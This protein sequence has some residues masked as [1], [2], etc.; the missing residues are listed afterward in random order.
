M[1]PDQEARL[2]ELSERIIE[3]ALLDADPQNWT[4]CEKTP[5]EM[6]E[7]ERGDAQWC[8][9][10]ATG[11]LAIANQVLV[12]RE[13]LKEQSKGWRKEWGSHD[14]RAEDEITRAENEASKL[15]KRVLD[16]KEPAG[17]AVR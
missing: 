8:R 11:T 7:D 10:V 13:R 1:R 17:R 14:P 16:K 2:D 5:A 15:L 12:L 9:K 6:T 4:A 3:Q